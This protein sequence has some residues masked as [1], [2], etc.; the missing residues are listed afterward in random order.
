MHRSRRLS[1]TA[2]FPTRKATPKAPRAALFESFEARRLFAVNIVFDYSLDTAGFFSD[3]ARKAILDQAA[4]EVTGTLTDTLTEIIPSGTDTWNV[5]FNDPSTGIATSIADPTIPEDT[6]VVYAGA[7][8]L[9]NGV[10][11]IGG[12]AGYNSTGST[13]FVNNIKSRGNTGALRTKP[14]DFA[15]FAGSLAFDTAESYYFNSDI[16][17]IQPTENDFLSVA[18]HELTHILGITRAPS[19]QRSTQNHKFYGANSVALY[20]TQ[21]PLTNDDGHFAEGT[22]VGGLEALMDP[23]ITTG[24]RKTITPLDFAALADTGW[25]FDGSALPPISITATEKTAD[26]RDGLATFLVSRTGDNIDNSSALIVNLILSGTATYKSDYRLLVNGV[27]I[28]GH[29]VTIPAGEDDLEVTVDPIDDSNVENDETVIITAGIAPDY[30]FDGKAATITILDNDL[31]D[32]Q[33]GRNPPAVVDIG[34][35]GRPSDLGAFG[36]QISA[37]GRYVTFISHSTNLVS[38]PLTTY[39][40]VYRRDM[41]AGT[42]ILLSSSS[43]GET[44]ANNDAIA[45]DISANGRYVAFETTANDILGNRVDRNGVSGR[46]LQGRAHQRDDSHQP[47]HRR[48]SRWRTRRDLRR[49]HTSA[50]HLQHPRQRL[51]EGPR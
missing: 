45:A 13:T 20:G 27:P 49:R 36:M 41:I 31:S 37:D 8:D 21:V 4:A 39:Y 10:L 9:P 40:Q 7:Y 48:R 15:P 34:L 26:E 5:T 14:T 47:Q 42:T 18:E 17:G 43:T 33:Q 30:V 51:R 12:F 3:P 11:G 44:E 32:I 6:I 46:L 19:F 29:Q 16:S 35:N 25:T 38:T 23:T 24:T 22:N 2:K 28:T 50:L 1:T